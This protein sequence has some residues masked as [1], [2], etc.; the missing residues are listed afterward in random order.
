MG[1]DRYF[2]SPGEF[3]ESVRGYFAESAEPARGSFQEPVAVTER[4]VLGYE[5]SKSKSEEA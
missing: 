1:D 3:A 2:G 4:A 5:V